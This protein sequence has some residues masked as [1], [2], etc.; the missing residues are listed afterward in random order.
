MPS[1]EVAQRRFATSHAAPRSDWS[2][3]PPRGRGSSAR[4]PP[5]RSP[6]APP[7]EDGGGE[8][9]RRERATPSAILY[10]NGG[11][12]REA[13]ERPRP[14][15]HDT[16]EVGAAPARPRGGALGGCGGTA[17]FGAGGVS[18]RTGPESAGPGRLALEQ[19]GRLRHPPGRAALRGVREAAEGPAALFPPRSSVLRPPL[20]H[21]GNSAGSG[22]GAAGV[23]CSV[24]GAGGCGSV[25]RWR[26]NRRLC[27]RRSPCACVTPVVTGGALRTPGRACPGRARRPP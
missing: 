5:L 23:P 3:A 25:A 2:K 13:R 12:A 21:R 19:R 8:R 17:S 6:R 26:G 16:A 7:R 20:S 22:A 27:A 18:V 9:P 24:A 1:P 14:G 15:P 10:R 11:G 4:I